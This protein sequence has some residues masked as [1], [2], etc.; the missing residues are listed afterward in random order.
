[1]HRNQPHWR[2]P[3]HC[4]KPSTKIRIV[5]SSSNSASIAF[6]NHCRKPS[7]KIRIV[8]FVMLKVLTFFLSIAE[9]HLLK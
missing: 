6:V 5:T 8:T 7:I 9:N 3:L 2:F 1:M 4:R